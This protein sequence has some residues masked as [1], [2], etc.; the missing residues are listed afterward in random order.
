VHLFGHRDDT[1][2]VYAATD[3]LLLPSAREGFS[4]VCAEAM[5]VGVPVLRTRTSGVAE[6]VVE[7]VTGR[8]VPID[9]DA[10][11]NAAVVMLSDREALARMGA[12]AARHVREHLTFDRQLAETV[13][14][15][16]RLA[17]PDPSQGR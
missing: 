16:N 12:A 10:F 11:L 6:T 5:S 14:L 4:L 9:H 1:P 2:A 13:A 8:S 17:N 15:Y 3:L 7:N